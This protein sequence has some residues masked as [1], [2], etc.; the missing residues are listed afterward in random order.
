[1]NRLAGLFVLLLASAIPSCIYIDG[2]IKAEIIDQAATRSISGTYSN[3]AVYFSHQ[4]SKW[5][6]GTSSLAELLQFSLDQY[7]TLQIARLTDGALRINWYVGE[8]ESLT[9]TIPPERLLAATDGA[10]ELYDDKGFYS[11]SN[12][13]NYNFVDTTRIFINA[14]GDLVTVR[15]KW[16]SGAGLMVIVPIAYTAYSETMALFPRKKKE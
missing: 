5:W 14:N 12:S 4:G 9:R 11:I 8:K 15:K 1:M 3:K 13:I 7:D 10:L 16:E 2:R 6:P